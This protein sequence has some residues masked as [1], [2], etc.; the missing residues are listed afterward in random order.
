MGERAGEKGKR[1]EVA[2]SDPGYYQLHDG[3]ECRGVV[4][5]IKELDD[6]QKGNL[7]L[8]STSTD[9]DRGVLGGGEKLC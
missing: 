9:R 2:G 5:K 6:G 3:E 7:E 1:G 8:D 4:E